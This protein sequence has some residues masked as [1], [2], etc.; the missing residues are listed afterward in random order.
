[1]TDLSTLSFDAFTARDELSTFVANAAVT[2]APFARSLTPLPTSRG[3]IAIPRVNPTGFSWV[4]EG[5]LIPD[6]DLNDD[7]DVIA[8]AKL[9]GL[10]T[11]SSEFV[12]DNELPISGLLGSAVADSMGPE[13]D[14]GLLFGAGGDEPEGVM[15]IAPAV[16][17]G[18]DYRADIIHAWG[19]LVDA[20]ANAETIVAFTSASVIA[21]E[22]A[23][24][25][26]EGVPIHADGAAAMV[27]PG[28]R[29]IGVPSLS[30]GETLVADVSRL[31][32]V[33]RQDFEAKMSDQAKFANDQIVLRIKGRFGIACPNPGK[34][35]R[36]IES[37]S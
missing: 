3:G 24:T 32:L 14:R 21:Y 15:D 26:S 37:A 4:G 29:M 9:A 16:A 6:V 17:G 34:T 13:L 20:G 19:Q 28:I 10:L 1:M 7:A 30:A 31:Y 36:T 27:G 18:A 2:G 5:G 23:R 11:M 25:T 22:L 12:D 35:I 33:L 8:T